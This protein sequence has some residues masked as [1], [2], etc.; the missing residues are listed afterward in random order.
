MK[1][2]LRLLPLL[3]LLLAATS[4]QDSIEVTKKIIKDL[5]QYSDKFFLSTLPSDKY[6]ISEL[7]GSIVKQVDLNRY[8]V[9][10]YERFIKKTGVAIQPLPVKDANIF[11][12][13]ITYKSDVNGSFVIG[14]ITI[15]KNEL[16]EFTI[17]D[18][19]T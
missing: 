18:L 15:E 9:I 1:N 13:R 19:L 3:T 4:S 10:N 12:K 14:G 8:R 2:I 17:Q 11:T 6:D 16:L 5:P 7:P